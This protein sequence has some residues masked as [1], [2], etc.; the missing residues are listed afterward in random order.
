MHKLRPDMRL[1]RIVVALAAG[2]VLALANDSVAAQPNGQRSKSAAPDAAPLNMEVGEMLYGSGGGGAWGSPSRTAARLAQQREIA[3]KAT[4]AKAAEFDRPFAASP[5]PAAKPALE[6]P[7]AYSPKTSDDA[8]NVAQWLIPLGGGIL[9]GL[10]VAGI[11]S[12]NRSRG[13]RGSASGRLLVVSVGSIRSATSVLPGSSL[14]HMGVIPKPSRRRG[15]GHS[16]PLHSRLMNFPK[17]RVRPSHDLYGDAVRQLQ[18]LGVLPV[19]LGDLGAGTGRQFWLAAGASDDLQMYGGG[20]DPVPN[21][22]YLEDASRMLA[23]IEHQ[24][25]AQAMVWSNQ[26]WQR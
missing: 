15:S 14:A 19:Q 23:Q 12:W 6:L 25:A 3:D 26:H 17:L 4:R 16:R 20:S 8:V 2:L 24:K 13:M 22:A 7:L 1:A 18:T 5:S 10:S 9:I 11:Y 21:Y